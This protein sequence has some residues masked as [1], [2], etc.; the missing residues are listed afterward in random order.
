MRGIYMYLQAALCDECL[1][2]VSL[3]YFRLCGVFDGAPLCLIWDRVSFVSEMFG[4]SFS[5]HELQ[6]LEFFCDMS[7]SFFFIC[8]SY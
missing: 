5:R 7:R 3:R 6:F 1:R 2:G 8:V 4:Q